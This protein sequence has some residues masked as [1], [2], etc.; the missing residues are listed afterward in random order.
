MTSAGDL[1]FLKEK[2]KFL[3]MSDDERRKGY[4]GSVT[5]LDQ[6]ASWDG[7]FTDKK[8][9]LM[10]VNKQTYVTRFNIQQYESKPDL[11]KKISL[12]EGDITKLEIEAIVNA[13]NNSLLGGGGVDGAIHRG[14]GKFL[15]EECKTLH[16]C[17]TGDA[18][19]TGGYNLPAK[20]VIHTVGPQGEKPGLLESCYKNCFQ[21]LLDNNLRSIAFPCISTGY[22][23]DSAAS[24]ALKCTRNFLEKN[25]S[26]V[27]RIVF[28]LF[29]AKDVEI[30]DTMMQSFFPCQ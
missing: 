4:K 5:T 13:A 3:K 8:E 22:P 27:D 25:S 1:N 24:V 15:L 30:Y 28:C 16:G 17:E 23:Q 11:N 21:R 2:E 9:R 12:W 14:A 6:I 20:Y 7:Y 18:K 29:L 19:I 10:K 26:K